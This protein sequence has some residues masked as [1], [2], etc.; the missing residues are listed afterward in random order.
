MV[1][2]GMIFQFDSAQ[3]T[4]LIMLSNG[5]TK[6]FSTHDWVDGSNQPKIGLEILYEDSDNLIKIKVP[7]EEEKSRIKNKSSAEKK[8]V[9]EV[10]IQKAEG[11]KETVLL[12]T[13]DEYSHN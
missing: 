6:E 10:N 9:E 5:E 13:L 1:F 2:I 4:G 3:G 11:N 12:A 7:S 8:N